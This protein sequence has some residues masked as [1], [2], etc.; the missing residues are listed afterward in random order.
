VGG[1]STS[2]KT[3]TIT[4]FTTTVDQLQFTLT[5]AG[6]TVTFTDQGD[7]TSI[8]DG[9]ALLGGVQGQYFFDKTNGKLAID[10]DGNGLIQATDTIVNLTGLDAFSSV[11]M[12]VVLTAVDTAGTLT[13]GSGNDRITTVIGNKVN[14]LVGGAGNDTY[15]MIDPG[16]VDVFVEAASGGTDTL[17]TGAALDIAGYKFGT[18]AAGATANGALTN[19]EQLVLKEGATFT[20]DATNFNGVTVAINN[21]AAGTLTIAAPGST[22]AAQTMNFG[23]ITVGAVSYLDANGDAATGV[24]LDA[25]DILN[26]T[27]GSGIDNVTTAPTIINNINTGVGADVITLGTGTDVIT[28]DGGL[29]IDTITGFDTTSGDQILLDVS[30]LVAAG[31]VAAGVTSVLGE[32]FDNNDVANP[33]GT[34]TAT[35]VQILTGAAAALDAKNFFVLD[36]GATKFLDAA[37]VTTALE[38]L[39]AAA[40]TFAGNVA[41]DDAFVV[42]YEN[43]TGGTTIATMNFAAGD[44]N[45]GNGAAAPTGANN[46][47]GT[48]IVTL[49]GVADASLL[50]ATEILLV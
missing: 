5:A 19:F 22:V 8:A 39:G 1:D 17:V 25:N 4:D 41:A 18:T 31:K 42:A 23:G 15:L 13:T 9:L 14:T 27:G 10:V 32:I 2:V 40:L 29:T 30:V 33:G 6:G 34:P 47:E 37:A 20:A 28:I 7:A 49:A 45:S 35:G 48:D 26:I 3:D 43:T 38:A 24:A 44:N 36:L 12:D 11:D 50:T 46:L 16:E 21:V